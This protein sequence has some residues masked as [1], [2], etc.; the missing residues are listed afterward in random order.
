MKS[1]PY[2]QA[3]PFTVEFYD[4]MPFKQVAG[5]IDFYL[6]YAAEAAGP[7]LE[8][9]CGTGR[10]L[11]PLAER[12]TSIT[13]LD[14]S[15]LMLEACRAKLESLTAPVRERVSLVEASMH[16]FKL[17]ER[18]G[19]IFSAFRSFQILIDVEDQLACLRCVS[20]HLQDDGRLILDVF[21][22][23]LPFLV[24]E[25]R[26]EESGREEPFTLPDGRVVDR[27]GALHQVQ[28]LQRRRA[29]RRSHHGRAD[30]RAAADA[31]RC[32]AR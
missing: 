24:D 11:M 18:F 10:V 13:G 28:R 9:G 31:R 29:R 26:K 8:L 19:M 32:R 15:P 21:D 4:H 16:D 2:Y 7:V 6:G 20:D 3:T 27:P 5:D 17:N 25:S 1:V 12:G 14:I 22:P 30:G 23:Y